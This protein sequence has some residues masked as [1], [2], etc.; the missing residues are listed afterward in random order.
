MLAAVKNHGHAL[1]FA[2]AEL[3]GDREIVLAAVK[4][5]GC[6]LLYASAE[7]RGDREI[8]LVAVLQYEYDQFRN[9]SDVALDSSWSLLKF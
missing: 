4:Q 1:R 7:L 8:V 3:R 9:E 5:R 6:A 2:S